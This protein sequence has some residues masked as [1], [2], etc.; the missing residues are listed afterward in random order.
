MQIPRHSFFQAFLA[1]PRGLCGQFTKKILFEVLREF[2]P[3]FD[4]G[5]P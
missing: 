5:R 1:Q 2:I 3:M 4:H